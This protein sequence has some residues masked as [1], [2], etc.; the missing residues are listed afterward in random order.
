MLLI[1]DRDRKCPRV[2]V[3]TRCIVFGVKS[4]PL[5]YKRKKLNTWVFGFP[6]KP[7][8][9]HISS[10]S[11]LDH[12]AL[13]THQLVGGSPY[14]NGKELGNRYPYGELFM[15]VCSVRSN[16]VEVAGW[17]WTSQAFTYTRAKSYGTLYCVD[18]EEI[19]KIS[20]P[21]TDSKIHVLNLKTGYIYTWSGFRLLGSSHNTGRSSTRYST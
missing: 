9:I 21:T 7:K 4:L 18:L 19:N 15:A 17:L 12:N 14:I 5:Y 16:A 20:Y 10:M 2:Y 6:K 8:L 11:R 13:L 3:W 1:L